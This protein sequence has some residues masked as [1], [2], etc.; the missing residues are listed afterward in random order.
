MATTIKEN[1]RETRFTKTHKLTPFIEESLVLNLLSYFKMSAI[2][3][4]QK[5]L[6]QSFFKI[7]AKEK[8]MF[9]NPCVKP[10]YFGKKPED[11]Y[12]FSHLF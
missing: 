6:S 11:F 8:N 2:I 10:E 9:R 4:Y 3:E 12:F 5:T 1:S 7:E